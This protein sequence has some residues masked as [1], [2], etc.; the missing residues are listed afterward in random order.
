MLSPPDKVF[1]TGANGYIGCWI[2]HELLDKGYFVRAAVRTDEKARTL[3]SLIT[4]KHPAL[5]PGSFE[6]VVVPEMLTDGAF[7]NFLGDIQGVIHTAT[8]VTFD[9]EDPEDYNVP[10]V[11][12]TM[13][14][15]KAA[16]KHKNVKRVVVT[17]STGAIAETLRAPE[18]TRIYTEDEWNDY[19]V[20][21]V[22]RLGKAAP[23]FEKYSASKVLSEKAAWEFCQENKGRLSFEL[24]TILPGWVFGVNTLLPSFSPHAPGPLTQNSLSQPLPD[25][26]KSPA[27]ISTVS[28]RVVWGQAFAMPP[29][30]PFLVDFSFVDVRDVAEMHIRAL[31]MEAAAGE[32]FLANPNLCTW[33][34][35]Y[36]AAHA[37]GI[38]PG[39]SKIHPPTTT[40][41]E[42]KA[43]Y[44]R[45]EYSSEK[46]KKKLGM[47]F[48]PLEV[49]LRDMVDDFRKRGWLEHLEV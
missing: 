8:P 20:E 48:R 6:C 29:A 27:D 36:N 13:G 35:W 16:A 24:C 1:V 28:A 44:P 18:E 38:L 14:I 41:T 4:S 42:G 11:N 17:S 15:I 22:S 31:E 26:P 39:L 43:S 34:D 32:R 19:A 46:A 7:D 25:D 10:A 21:T 49:T 3:S 2:V 23:G 37:M 12:G 5:P 45:L 40:S 30:E 33:Q 47:V 9:L